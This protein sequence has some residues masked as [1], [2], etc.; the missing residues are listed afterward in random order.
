M[1]IVII[2]ISLFGHTSSEQKMQEEFWQEDKNR[3]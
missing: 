1:I 2:I 3:I